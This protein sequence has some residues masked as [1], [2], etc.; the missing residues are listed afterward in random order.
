MEDQK[1]G[2]GLTRSQDFATERELKPKVKNF[3]KYQ[4]WKK[5]RAKYFSQTYHRPW[6]GGKTPSRWAFFF[7]FC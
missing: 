3:Q 7:F 1:P 6:S 2:P 5:W 4:N